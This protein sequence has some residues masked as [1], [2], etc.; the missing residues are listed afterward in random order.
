MKDWKTTTAPKTPTL[1]ER[2]AAKVKEVAAILNGFNMHPN[3]RA[4]AAEA[5]VDG[6]KLVK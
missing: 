3:H 5:L 1:E 4:R 6:L 2:R